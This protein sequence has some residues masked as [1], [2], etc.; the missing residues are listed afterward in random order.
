MTEKSRTVEETAAQIVALVGNIANRPDLAETQRRQFVA[1]TLLAKS[2][3]RKAL[4]EAC[5][6]LD[7]SGTDPTGRGWD[8]IQ[9]LK[10]NGDTKP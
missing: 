6:A 7:R 4:E 5:D 2:E 8:A 9:A 10:Q 3:R 1:I